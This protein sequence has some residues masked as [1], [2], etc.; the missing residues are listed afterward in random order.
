MEPR[1]EAEKLIKKYISICQ[2]WNEDVVNS[3]TIKELKEE[4]IQ[5]EW[6]IPKQCAILTV[7]EILNNVMQ[8]WELP[9]ED[10][11]FITQRTYWKEVKIELNK[12]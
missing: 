9:S 4:L 5:L 12:L 2:R 10:K 7:D 1:E 8:W 6:F 3:K 11:Y